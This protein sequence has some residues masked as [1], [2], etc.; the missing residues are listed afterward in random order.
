[1]DCSSDVCSSDLLTP[2]FT[3][4]VDGA[5]TTPGYDFGRAAIV[6]A[7]RGGGAVRLG[8]ELGREVEHQAAPQ[9]AETDQ[10]TR[11]NEKARVGADR[12]GPS[13]LVPRVLH[14]AQDLDAPILG[15]GALIAETLEGNPH[16]HLVAPIGHAATRLVHVVG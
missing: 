1:R 10:A 4:K 3:T 16:L 7:R 6:V 9:V 15:V 12:G 5:P 8:G 14:G 2:E 11:L 13:L